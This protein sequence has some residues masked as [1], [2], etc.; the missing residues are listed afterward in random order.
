MKYESGWHLGAHYYCIIIIVVIVIIALA[1]III[2]LL[3]QQ[4]LLNSFSDMVLFVLP[5]FSVRYMDH[6]KTEKQCR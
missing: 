1:F 5:P 2:T 3:V 4:Q 6:N